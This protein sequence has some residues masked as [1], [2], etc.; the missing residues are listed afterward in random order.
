MRLIDADALSKQ[1]YSLGQ[2]K[3]DY[4]PD[5]LPHAWHEMTPLSEV[6]TIDAV[7][8]VRCRDCKWWRGR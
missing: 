2:L 4:E 6:P 5:G 8:V 7:P 3:W 1:G